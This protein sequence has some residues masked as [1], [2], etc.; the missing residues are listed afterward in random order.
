MPNEAD[1][2]YNMVKHCSLERRYN[3]ERSVA[4]L[5]SIDFDHIR[6]SASVHAPPSQPPQA[7]V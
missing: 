7:L 4:S 2:T 1:V 6:H 5:R 3:I